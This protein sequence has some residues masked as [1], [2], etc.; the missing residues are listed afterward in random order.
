MLAFPMFI[1]TLH[2]GFTNYYVYLYSMGSNAGAS[3]ISYGLNVYQ[4]PLQ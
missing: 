3:G 1:A 2:M 4:F